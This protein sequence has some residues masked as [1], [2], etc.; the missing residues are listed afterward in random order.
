MTDWFWKTVAFVAVAATF[1][2]VLTGTAYDLPDNLPIDAP[3]DRPAD[4]PRIVMIDTCPEP[5]LGYT[6]KAHVIRCI[7]G[8]TVVVEIRKK[9]RIR[10]LDC[11]A[12]ETRTRD[13][14][15]KKRGLEAK[16]YLQDWIDQ[17]E[18]TLH[19]PGNDDL[20]K[21]LTLNRVLG[22][23]WADHKEVSTEMVEAG[24]ATKT[25]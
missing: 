2:A 23:I 25:K 21:I 17:R 5:P 24:H 9:L 20:S 3:L 13:L 19:I 8:D 6:T 22:R 16:K 12:A 1:W 15:E 11:W 4:P 10:L 14:E 18:V 7:D